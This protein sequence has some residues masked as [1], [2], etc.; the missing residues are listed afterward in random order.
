MSLRRSFEFRLSQISRSNEHQP[1]TIYAATRALPRHYYF[2][3]LSTNWYQSQEVSQQI[4]NVEDIITETATG[5]IKDGRTPN[6]DWHDRGMH[7]HRR[8]STARR[9]L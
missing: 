1:R 7:M 2:M 4:A 6:A 3:H 8:C 5:P 9:S